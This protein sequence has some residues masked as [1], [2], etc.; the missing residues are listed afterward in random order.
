VAG[1][2]VQAAT[3]IA[4]AAI[5]YFQRRA[6]T[7]EAWDMRLFLLLYIMLSFIPQASAGS[8]TPPA[9]PA[10]K[11]D[12]SKMKHTGSARIDKV[13]D[14]QTVLMKDGKIVRLLGLEYPYATGEEAGMHIIAAKDRLEKLLPENTEVMIWQSYNSK[15]GRTNRMGH[16]LAHL[17]AKK[18]E[19]WINGTAVAEGL[20]YAM[21]DTNNAD[22][23]EQLY[24]L[25]ANAMKDKR[26]L[27]MEKSA[28]GLLSP[29]NAMQ[30]DGMF[31]VVEGVVTRAATS[32]NN[33]YLNFGSDIRSDFTV[34]ITPPIRKTLARN[35]IDPMGFSGKKVRVRGWI[36]EWNGPFIEL[37]S[38]E[39][40]QVLSTQP[41]TIL[42]TEPSPAPTTTGQINP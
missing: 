8:N 10:V 13:I 40:I 27:W 21:T 12:F 4:T 5:R 42:S 39:R 29:E 15:T 19:R 14:A 35:S 38:A 36:R 20:A 6:F 7:L 9:S 31:R 26:G 3:V 37:E 18:D 11:G 1:L 22:M 16:T 41:P 2:T 30:G 34:M 23:A 28:Y 17:A 32:K 33:L 24:T 25:E